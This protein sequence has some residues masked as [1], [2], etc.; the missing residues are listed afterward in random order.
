MYNNYVLD[1]PD[2]FK[3]SGKAYDSEYEQEEPEV[4][5]D[6]DFDEEWDKLGAESPPEDINSEEWE[7]V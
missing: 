6:P 3:K 4:F 2:L 7:E 5:Y 1:N